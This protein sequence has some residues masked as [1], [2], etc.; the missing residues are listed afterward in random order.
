MISPAERSTP[1][2]A[3]NGN[4][5]VASTFNVTAPVFDTAAVN[6]MIEC[7]SDRMGCDN[8]TTMAFAEPP[9]VAPPP[10]RHA[11]RQLPPSSRALNR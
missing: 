5:A 8:V 2:A 1:D 10:Y 4:A 6:A 7:P 9:T 3:R 11:T